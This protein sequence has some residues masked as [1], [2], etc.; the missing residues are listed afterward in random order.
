MQI[1]NELTDTEDYLKV[2]D[3]SL[4]C[5]ESITLF[6]KKG[7]T[8][9]AKDLPEGSSSS[10]KDKTENKKLTAHATELLKNAVP[11]DDLE[12]LDPTEIDFINEFL[13]SDDDDIA[14]MMS[15]SQ[16][17]V[18]EKTNK[19]AGTKDIAVTKEISGTKEIA[20]AKN[21]AVKSATTSSETPPKVESSGSPSNSS[22]SI[23]SL[24]ASSW[25]QLLSLPSQQYLVVERMYSGARRFVVFDFGEP[26]LLTDVFIPVC[27]GFV[28]VSVDVW[29]TGEERDAHRLVVCTDIGT[30]PLMLTDLQPPP[31]CRFIKLTNQGRYGMVTGESTVSL[32]NF[33]GHRLLL[34]W[35]S[36]SSLSLKDHT[37]CSSKRQAQVSVK[38]QS[39]GLKLTGWL[40]ISYCLAIFFCDLM[41]D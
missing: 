30:R 39:P 19:L 14:E 33:Y 12:N 16:D 36:R 38:R 2:L 40:S 28:S 20:G 8:S 21:I 4:P 9:L 35:I 29:L 24:P 13:C 26:V 7:S 34:P 3:G 17:L 18:T 6:N 10:T 15:N 37:A 1:I 22:S 32:G 11:K 41:I 23:G 27:D 5:Y 25:Q 31:L